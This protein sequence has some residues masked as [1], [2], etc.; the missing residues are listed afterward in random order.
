MDG[1]SSATLRSLLGN[2]KHR[3]NTC[4][5]EEGKLEEARLTFLG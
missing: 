4:D 2:Q 5:G 1:T 3:A